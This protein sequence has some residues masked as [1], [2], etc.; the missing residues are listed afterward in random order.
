MYGGV[1]QA[2]KQVFTLVANQSYLSH[3]GNDL[4]STYSP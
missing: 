1:P 4:E 2:A 3:K